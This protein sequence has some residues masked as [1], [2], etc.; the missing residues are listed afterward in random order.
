MPKHH[1]KT[2]EDARMQKKISSSRTAVDGFEHSSRHFDALEDVSESRGPL[3]KSSCAEF[4]VSDL[5]EDDEPVEPGE[6]RVRSVE[7]TN[8]RKSHLQKQEQS[9][10]RLK[11]TASLENDSRSSVKTSKS[12]VIPKRTKLT[13]DSKQSLKESSDS[14]IRRKA[15][16]SKSTSEA[17]RW[18]MDDSTL[19]ESSGYKQSTAR[20][21]KQREKRNVSSRLSSE[22]SG[23]SA[24]K[25]SLM[26]DAEK[27]KMKS[28][29]VGPNSVKASPP[30]D[31]LVRYSPQR[32]KTRSPPK[33]PIRHRPL[34]RH[35]SSSVSTERGAPSPDRR[36]FCY[37]HMNRR[38]R[39]S[40]SPGPTRKRC[41]SDLRQHSSRQSPT[42]QWN[43]MSSFRASN[44]RPMGPASRSPSSTSSRSSFSSFSG[45]RVSSRSRRQASRSR[46]DSASRRNCSWRNNSPP[47]YRRNTSRS[48]QSRASSAEFS[49]VNRN[50]ALTRKEIARINYRSS[51]KSEIS[52]KGKSSTHHVDS[53]DKKDLHHSQQNM[54]GK[55][56]KKQVTATDGN[57][58][59]VKMELDKVKGMERNLVAEATEN[60]APVA[61]TSKIPHPHQPTCSAFKIHTLPPLPLPDL[62]GMMTSSSPKESLLKGRHR[63]SKPRVRNKLN[64]LESK[65]SVACVDEYEVLQQIGEG[66]Y[67]QVYK[68]KHRGLSNYD[69]VALKKVRLDNE[70]EGFP[71]TAIREIKILRQLNHPNIVQ[72][73]DIARDRCIE[74][75]GFYLMF[76]YMDHDLMGLLESGFVQFSTLHIGSFIKQLLSGL[77][78]CHSKNFLHRDI[79]CSNILLN[80]NGEIKLADFGLA[81]LYQ[82]DKVRPYTNKVITLWYRPPELLLGEERYTPAIDVW[83]VGCILGELFTRRPLFQGGS[84]LMQ[85][86]LISRICGSPT[87]L[88]WPEVVDLPLFETIRLKKLYKRCLRDQFRQIPTAAL[89]LL[90]QML[91]LDPKKRCSAE[92]AL[93]SPWLVSINPGNVTPPKLPTWQDCHEMWSKRRRRNKEMRRVPNQRDLKS[94]KT[95]TSNT[96]NSSCGGGGGSSSNNNNDPTASSSA[97]AHHNIW[98]CSDGK[99]LSSI[100]TADIEQAEAVEGQS[101][102]RLSEMDHHQ[103]PSGDGKDRI[104]VDT[105]SPCWKSARR[106][107]L[108]EASAEQ[109]SSLNVK[110]DRPVS[111]IEDAATASSYGGAFRSSIRHS[112]EERHVYCE[113]STQEHGSSFGDINADS[114]ISVELRSY[115]ESQ[116]SDFAETNQQSPTSNSAADG[117]FTEVNGCTENVSNNA[118]QRKAGHRVVREV[119]SPESSNKIY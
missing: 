80:N 41:A 20:T 12:T 95:S 93:R 8:A 69:L 57:A 88:V 73:K 36:E 112:D 51:L 35:R 56:L 79:K 110:S 38:Y 102:S 113:Q 39:E 26:D 34:N 74:K 68:A 65:W 16:N 52:F 29:R 5:N 28:R 21:P 119:Q 49:P 89:D 46:R 84:E 92:A 108:L 2:N 85:L 97:A 71:I 1:L 23:K 99:S 62:T 67:G 115:G 63:L 77:A 81:R 83:S 42:V 72:L 32:L 78:Y 66:T 76:E 111:N 22:L 116:D 30:R 47:R 13:E 87:P 15:E 33:N 53:S 90:D 19:P 61:S 18:A 14:T 103:L 31:R 75:G 40:P 24:L 50:S 118:L 64:R 101:G 27:P 25:M 17:V 48:S 7:S 94:D 45:Y 4:D 70:K 109:S 60:N 86:E 43:R 105:V 54:E 58:D 11:T 59:N 91:T 82:R 44:R 98:K 37:S 10:R 117:S 3:Y 100:S 106:V 55:E 6:I 104:L 9:V 96:N 107:G 114:G